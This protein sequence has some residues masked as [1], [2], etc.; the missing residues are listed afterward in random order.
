[1][2]GGG[3]ICALQRV[4]DL[5]SALDGIVQELLALADPAETLILFA[6]VGNPLAAG[7]RGDPTRAP[8]AART[9]PFAPSPNRGGGRG[10]G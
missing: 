3:V 1:M 5:N 7:G 4:E 8:L 6:D 10:E 9:L 2:A